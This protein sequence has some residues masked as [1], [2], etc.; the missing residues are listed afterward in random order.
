MLYFFYIL[1]FLAGSLLAGF[2]VERLSYEF[3]IAADTLSLG[4]SVV[5]PPFSGSLEGYI[6]TMV[7][8][9]IALGYHNVGEKILKFF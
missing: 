1:G 5:L 7:L 8:K 6:G 3:Q 9:G 4:I 2:L